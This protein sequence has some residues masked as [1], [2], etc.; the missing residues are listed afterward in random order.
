MMNLPRKTPAAHTGVG[1]GLMDKISGTIEGHQKTHNDEG[2]LVDKN[3]WRHRGS[4]EKPAE[5]A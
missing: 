3:Q 1:G 5:D 2:G 4:S